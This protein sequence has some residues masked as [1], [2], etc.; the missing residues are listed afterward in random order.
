MTILRNVSL[1]E[2]HLL[3]E[4]M[5]MSDKL[6]AIIVVLTIVCLLATFIAK[7]VCDCIMPV[8]YEYG[9]IYDISTSIRYACIIL[10]MY[11]IF[12]QGDNNH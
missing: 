7:C 11:F 8:G 1:L 10:S 4:V 9:V 6:L 5:V 12:K 2:D 3:D